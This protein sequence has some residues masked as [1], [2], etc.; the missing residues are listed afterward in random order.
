[1]FAITGGVVGFVSGALIADHLAQRIPRVS[2]IED[3]N[4][5]NNHVTTLM[6]AAVGVGAVAGALV[7]EVLVRPFLSERSA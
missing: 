4:R 1:M 2:G 3:F 7:F 6:F 5:Y